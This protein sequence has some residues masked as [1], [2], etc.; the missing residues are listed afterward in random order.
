MTEIATDTVVTI[1]FTMQT[2]L[3]DG[4]VKERPDESMEFIFGVERQPASL[5]EALEH[6][7]AGDKLRVQI[8]PDEIYGEYDP[9]LVHEIPREG[10]IQSRIKKGQFYRQMKKGSLVSFKVLDVRPDT[11]LADFN[12]PMA[13]IAV[14]V[15]LEV[16]SVREASKKEIEAAIDAQNKRS[17]G[18]G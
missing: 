7:Q 8:P 12:K 16:L 1:K 17:I 11:V 6:A 2:H 3:P 5:E 15:D 18:C 10:L 9:V 13:G 4:S 14:S